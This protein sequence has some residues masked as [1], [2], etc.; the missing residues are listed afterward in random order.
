[1]AINPRFTKPRSV[2]SFRIDKDCMKA[3]EHIVA[4]AL[5]KADGSQPSVADCAKAIIEQ[6]ARQLT[7]RVAWIKSNAPDQNDR[8]L[9][10]KAGYDLIMTGELSRNDDVDFDAIEAKF[11]SVMCTNPLHVIEAV[12]RGLTLLIFKNEQLTIYHGSGL[13]RKFKL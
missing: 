5:P 7:G 11:G 2:L 9:A 3:L 4:D 12:K 13:I 6:S 10:A 1:M 8:T